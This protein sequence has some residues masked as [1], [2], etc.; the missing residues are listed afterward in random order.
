MSIILKYILKNMKEKKLRSMLIIVSLTLSVIV[1]TLCLTLKDNISEKY[2][3]FLMKTTG[4]SD[5]LLSK[6]GPFEESEVEDFSDNYK[7]AKYMMYMKDKTAV[8]GANINEL[9]ENKMIKSQKQENL[10]DNEVIITKKTAENK[11]IKLND[12]INILN[13]ELKVIEIV[14]KYGI[15]VE[16][17]EEQPIYLTS[18]EEANKI[19][20]KNIEQEKKAQLDENKTYIVGAYIDVVDDNI[21]NAK[22]ELKGINND[23]EV[24]TIKANIEESLTQINSLMMMM[25]VITTLI[26]FYIISSILKL[27]LEERISVIGTFRSIGISKR[28]TNFLL[29]LENSFYGIISSALGVL[30][31][32]FLIE[33]ISKTF[34]SV[35][36]MELTSKTKI[37]PLYMLIVV[38]FTILIQ[39]IITFFELRK[40]R[41]KSI[42]EIIFDTQDTKYKIKKR[43]IVFGIILII[44]SIIIYL[45]NDN[46]D[47]IMGLIPLTL[48]VIGFVMIIPIIIKIISIILSKILKNR[49]TSYL[50][51]KNVADNKILVSTTILLF[52][53]ISMTTMIYNISVTITNTYD[54]FDKVTHYT[55][56]ISNV[57]GEEKQ[58]EYIKDIDG[59]KE[60]SFYYMSMGYFKIDDKEKLFAI[61]G[62]DKQNDNVFKLFRSIEFNKEEADNLKED[63]ILLDE[64]FARKNNYK[65]NDKMKINGEQ[66]FD[67]DYYFTVKGYIDATNTT[68]SRTVGMISKDKYINIFNKSNKTILIDS[69]LPDD[70]MKEKLKEEVK[71]KNVN[72]RSYQEW[73]G[74][75]KETTKQIMNIVYGILVLGITLAF[76]GLIN[77]SLV[78]FVQRK[79]SIAVLNSI[80]MTKTQLFK[81]ALEENI[82][83]FIIAVIPGMVLSTIINLYITKTLN[84]MSLFINMAFEIKGILILLG[85]IF[86]L[87]IIETIVPIVKIRKLNLIKEIKY[88]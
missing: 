33:P 83:S 62:Y 77:N 29:Y 38:A 88:E 72:I 23:F 43:K 63:E 78:A 10:K 50:A 40:N 60:M 82:F 64:A 25:L 85:T 59:V 67:E 58:S 2:T 16:E 69:D 15:F 11:N 71:D 34:I 45:K 86:I 6:E 31:A 80:C 19:T 42:R 54:A 79:R 21:E 35:S 44:A 17:T 8:I 49:K 13:T 55:M 73:I 18:I 66:F 51:S 22:K 28:A 76:V 20:F 7:V 57:A 14:E 61:S 5:I 56:R 68:T 24:I 53:I 32:S 47:F 26:A 81:M 1:L 52:I 65:I 48:I 12:T 74:S 46:Y 30:I 9:Q 75:D 36:D 4:N 37:N 39:L 41:K 87:T 27:V 84:S 3:E 70:V